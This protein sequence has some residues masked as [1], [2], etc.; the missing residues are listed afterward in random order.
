LTIWAG[1]TI[2][3]EGE[4]DG[5]NQSRTKLELRQIILNLLPNAAC[6][7]SIGGLVREISGY[8]EQELLDELRKLESEKLVTVTAFNKKWHGV[9]YGS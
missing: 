5:E 4:F 6:S 8:T 7:A 1:Y 2:R 9:G 3:S